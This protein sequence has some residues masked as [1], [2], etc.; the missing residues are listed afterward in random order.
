MC[1]DLRLGAAKC[2]HTYASALLYQACAV[3][4]API[5]DE[6]LTE[7]MKGAPPGNFVTVSPEMRN[8]LVIIA[9]LI[10]AICT[11]LTAQLFCLGPDSTSSAPEPLI[12]NFYVSP[13]GGDDNSGSASAPWRTIQHASKLAQ[14]GWTVHVAPG[15]YDVSSLVTTTSG[16]ASARIRYI[17]DIKWGAKL[18]G[19]GAEII[20]EVDASYV[21]IVGFDI[22]GPNRLGIMIGCSGSGSGH[23]HIL[24][25]NIHDLTISAGCT[26]TGGAAIATS[27]LPWGNG[28]NWILGNRVANIGVSMIG[29]CNS[30]QGIYVGTANDIIE[31][32]IVSGVALAAIQQWHGA[33]NSV[34]VNN[35]VFHSKVG[36]L[37]GNGDGGALPGGSANS[38]VANN[39]VVNNTAIGI[40]EYGLVGSG[41]SYVNNLVWNNPT[42]YSVSSA[43]PVGNGSS[44]PLFVNYQA[45]GSGDYHLRPS[46]PAIDKGTN[47]GAPLKDFD[48]GPRPEGPAWDVGAYE[49]GATP[50]A[51]PWQ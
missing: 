20:W 15:T 49:E 36:I 45:D 28:S 37:I 40:E 46:S 50:A 6:R 11:A 17:S 1:V 32:N 19:S 43:S 41:N 7:D 31:N 12:T 4:I 16:T 24:Y 44:D 38:Y 8:H 2:H 9:L 29:T 22:T 25:N 42:N 3:G 21:D 33:T 13:A 27:Y 10:L 30:I 39:I 48:G 51:W 47:A 5:H 18:V 26:G 34:I 23:D 14:P 35:T